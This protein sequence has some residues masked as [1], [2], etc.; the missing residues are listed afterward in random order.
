MA[1]CLNLLS[2]TVWS[3]YMLLYFAYTLYDTA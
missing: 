2:L 3:N 1:E